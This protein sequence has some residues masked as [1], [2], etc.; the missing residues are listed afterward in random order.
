[1]VEFEGVTPEA[2]IRDLKPDVVVKG[3]DY[4]PPS[5]KPMP[6]RE[7]VESYGGSIAFVP[8][9]PGRSTTSV[10]DDMRVVGSRD[11]EK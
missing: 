6:E 7:V 8:L 3:A 1:V 5:G 4:A 11:A 10:I 2:A 9:I